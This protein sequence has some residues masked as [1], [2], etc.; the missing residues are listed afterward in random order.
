MFVHFTQKVNHMLMV[1]VTGFKHFLK[2]FRMRQWSKNIFVFAGLL[3]ALDSV[4]FIMV[5][6]AVFAFFLFCGISSS[7]YMINDVVDIEKDRL[8]PVKRNRPL[9]SGQVKAAHAAIAAILLSA[10]ILFLS[11]RLNVYFGFTLSSY[12]LLNL[13]YSFKLKHYVFVDVII[14]SSGFVLRALSGI[15]IAGAAISLWLLLSVAFLTLFLGVNKRKKELLLLKE[16]STAHRKNLS[17]YSIGLINEMIPMLTSCTVITYSFFIIYESD[18]KHM[19][20]TIPMVLYGI[21]RYQYLTNRTEYGESP[22][23]VLLRDKPTVLIM[24]LW[25]VMFGLNVMAL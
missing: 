22:E 11:F 16:D 12:F 17:Q 7:V 23:L 21:F 6:Q 8:H 4:D 5:Q 10:T 3:L 14:I 1:K 20:V 19:I 25:A 2:L 24:L 18:S 13:L 15:L 9:P